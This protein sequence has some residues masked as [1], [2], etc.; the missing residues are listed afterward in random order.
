MIRIKT[1]EDI[2][3]MREG[4]KNLAFVVSEV[5]KAVKP[6][7]STVDLDE[8]ARKLIESF[9]DKPAFLDYMPSG[10]KRGFPGTICA[11]INHEIVHGVPNEDPQ[12]LKDGDIIGIDCGLIH[13]GMY[14][15]HAVTVGVGNIS[16]EAQKLLNVTKEALLS[17][18]K[19]AKPGNHIGDIGACVQ[20]HAIKH[21]YQIIEGLCGHGVGYAIH[22]D[23]Y[24]PNYGKKGEGEELRVGMVIAIEPMFSPTTGK[25]KIAKD[26]FTYLTADGSLA[27][28]FEHTV[29]ILENGPEILT[30][31]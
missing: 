11:S 3:K 18:I 4:G 8:L 13:K 27:T 15:D 31:L 19:E 5:A 6:G 25:T 20:K 14:L 26:G 30:M 24:V 9:G 12:I 2:Q 29:A 7:V 22:E 21:K 17:A 16:K 28:Q 10:A 1:P 23:P